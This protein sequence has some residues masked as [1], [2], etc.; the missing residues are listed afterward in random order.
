MHGFTHGVWLTEAKDRMDLPGSAGI[1]VVLRRDAK[2]ER[3]WDILYVGKALCL[4]SRVRYTHHVLEGMRDDPNILILLY[5]Y[6]EATERELDKFERETIRN[7]RPTL[8]RAI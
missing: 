8:N 4:S 6:P 2:A 5:P 3:G 1:Y 7:L